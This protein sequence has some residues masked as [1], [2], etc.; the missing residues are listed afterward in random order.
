MDYEQTNR[1]PR[2]QGLDQQRRNHPLY[3]FLAQENKGIPLSDIFVP[4]ERIL[5]S[6][7]NRYFGTAHFQQSQSTSFENHRT[8]QIT[9]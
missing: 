6:C 3:R 5:L 9:T 8:D 7:A 4:M 1:G 2:I